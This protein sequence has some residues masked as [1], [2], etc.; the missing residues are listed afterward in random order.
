VD[1]P[2]KRRFDAVLKPTEHFDDIVIRTC[3][4]GAGGGDRFFVDEGF[5]G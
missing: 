5:E 3:S 4:N 1:H 2:R